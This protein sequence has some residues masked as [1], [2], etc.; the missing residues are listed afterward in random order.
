[1]SSAFTSNRRS[2]SPFW[3][4]AI[5]SGLNLFNYLDR[6]VAVV[7]AEP[8][9]LSF[10]LTDRQEGQLNTAFMLGYFLTAPVF[11]YLGDRL[12][13]KWLIAAGIFVWSLGTVLSGVATGFGSLLGYRAL[14]GLGEASYAT[15]SPSLISD[16]YSPVRR[17]NAL[18]IFYVAIPVGSALGYMVGSQ[19]SAAWGW[20]YAF[21]VAGLPGL[22]LAVSLLPFREQERGQAEHRQ[23]EA[24]AKP[25]A[26]DILKLLLLPDYSLVVWGYVAYTFAMGG[27][28]FWGPAYLM[29]V[30]KMTQV[31]A[32]IYFG[33]VTAIA[34]LLGT[35]AGGFA[36]TA[37][38]KRNPAAYA[39]V[40][41][42]S[43]LLAVPCAAW[44]FLGGTTT[45]LQWGLGASIF[46][47]FLGTGPVNTLILETV[48][49]NLRAG[50]MAMAIF[51]I[52]LFGDFK[53]AEIVGYL[54]DRSGS[55]KL[56]VLVLPALLLVGGALWLALGL[57]TLY[58]H[59]RQTPR[60][61]QQIIVNLR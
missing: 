3:L 9:R 14:V 36:A 59:R 44:A 52:H 43:T 15:I 1:M 20:R 60:V 46:L 50:G 5:L 53:S 11:G 48:P 39:L 16:A 17:N 30:S 42:V 26:K 8:I 57:K 58:C 21:V 61:E 19:I 22:L 18:T 45:A 40:L 32:G 12:T 2:L 35:F 31:Q 29:R 13:R 51:M 37:W 34:G 24:A 27:F 54:S 4:L 28:G 7:V 49:V 33:S 56:A 25:K 41:G 10:G 55:L 47:A 38:R 23:S 6:Y